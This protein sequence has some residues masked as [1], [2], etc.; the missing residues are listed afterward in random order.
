MQ[1]RYSLIRMHGWGE[2][3]REHRRSRPQELAVVD[4]AVR[5]TYPELD[6]RVNRLCHLL[7]ASGVQS[8]GRVLWLGQNSHRLLEALLACARLGALFV[9][10]NWRMSVDETVAVVDDFEPQVVLWQEAEV[11]ATLSAARERCQPAAQW[12]QHDGGAEGYEARLAQQPDTDPQDAHESG[13]DPDQPLLGIFTAAFEGRPNAALL[14]HSALM[15]QC[16]LLGYAQWITDRSCFL[17]SGPL[18]HIGTLQTLLTVFLF[19]GRNV[20]VARVDAAELLERIQAEGVTHAFLMPPTIEQMRQLNAQGRYDLSSLFATPDMKDYRI[21]MVMPAQAPLHRAPMGY[22]QSETVGMITMAWLGGSGAGRVS[23]MA[24][25]RIVDDEG[26]D[27]PPGESG[28]I[29]VRGTLVMNGYDRR[30]AENAQRTPQGWHRT[31]DLGRRL[32]D[33]SV[34]FIGPKTVLIKSAAE[35]IYPAEVEGCLRTHPAVADVC[36]IGVPD[37]VWTQNVKAVVV[38]R[39]GQAA[40]PEELIEHCRARIAAYKKPKQVVFTERLPRTAA[41]ALDRKAVDA[42]FGGGGYPAIG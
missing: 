7:R 14:S 22:G 35:N 10:A 2:V 21:P 9:P 38:L 36:V 39:E 37:P 25:L 27:V 19:G 5:L 12:I 33:G 28:E 31:R 26:S 1:D 40:K 3:L 6:A 8:Q 42:A 18:F 16:L 34:A 32:A 17:T 24:Q 4:G 11:G 30:D 23:P 13:T 20:F 15:A 29:V 41:G